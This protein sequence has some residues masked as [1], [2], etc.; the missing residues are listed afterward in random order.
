MKSG[1]SSCKRAILKKDITRFAPAWALYTVF[2]LLCVAMMWDQDDYWF[3]DGT[4]D[5]IIW[6]APVNFLF[7][8]VCAQLLFGDLYNIRM[9]NALHALPVRRDSWFWLHAVS[10]ILFAVVPNLLIG[11]LMMPLAGQYWTVGAAWAAVSCLEFLCFYGIAVFSALCVGNRFAMVV[12]YAILNFLAVVLFWLVERLYVPLLYGLV[13]DSL[14]FL[15]FS[16]VCAMISNGQFVWLKRLY[17]A[18]QYQVFEVAMGEGWWYLLIWAA[19]GIALLAAAWWLYRRRRLETAGDFLAVKKLE[20]VFLVLYT[21]C[22]GAACQIF[23]YM[24]ADSDQY[25]L[26]FAVGLAIGFFTG[27]MLLKRTVRVFRVKA[28]VRFAIL[29]AVVGATLLAA[30]LDIFGV[31]QWVPET[32][33]V[34]SIDIWLGDATTDHNRYTACSPED[35]GAIINVHRKAVENGG[36]KSE[37]YYMHEFSLEYTLADGSTARRSYYVSAGSAEGAALERYFSTPECV[38]GYPAEELDAFLAQFSAVCVSDTYFQGADMRGL[39]EAILLDCQSGTMAQNWD[40]HQEEDMVFWLDFEYRDD[41]GTPYA[42]YGVDVYEGCENT[43]RWL[44]EHGLEPW[45]KDE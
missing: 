14:P 31:I 16:P 4:V 18:G 33:Q 30:R 11:G 27:L 32:E 10:G 45:G 28:V 42:C 41:H 43:I 13:I 25:Y 5:F 38:L 24:F 12:V 21:L 36:E 1:T 3:A 9:C 20:P 2:L 8:P 19:V 26:F 40:Y 15:Q 34:Q 37:Y 17:T 39:T 22:A 23:C 44:R 35:I 29:A 7:A 6:M